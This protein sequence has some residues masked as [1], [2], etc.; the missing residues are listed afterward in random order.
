VLLAAA[1]SG[2]A[3]DAPRWKV[4]LCKPDL[5]VNWCNVDMRVT[6]IAANGKRHVDF[7]P[8]VV[9][10][11]VDCFYLYPSLPGNTT[12]LKID[13]SEKQVAIIQAA[14]FGQACRVFAPMYRQS[15]DET[16][17]ADSLAAWRD[18]LAHSNHGRG[19]VLIGHSQGAYVL[20]R[21]IQE[22]VERR[23][24]VRKLVVSAILLGGSVSVKKGSDTGGTFTRLP[25]CRR[26]RQAGCIVAYSTWGR[27]PPPDASFE[28]VGGP[29]Q[30]I[31]CVNPARPGA[32]GKVPITPVFP[33]FAPEGIVTTDVK[34]DTLY[35]AFRHKYTA[36]CV[37]KGS[38]SWLLVEDVGTPGD[39]R[40]RVQE[41][42]APTW[43]L[44]AA[45][46]N[47]AL[48]QLVALVRM[49]AAAWLANR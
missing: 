25:V 4:W 26:P 22:H 10:Q 24:A 1:T 7:G 48:E 3:A 9:R 18:Y 13:D 34:V 36:R 31:V 41:V 8:Q 45:D 29:S 43:G 19:V 30:Q 20:E 44:H 38:R 47:I 27:T 21:L 49:Q 32:T 6:E 17:Y 39:K 2:S 40:Q 42:A 35:V 33:W 12:N 28:H 15:P 23:P 14:R 16:A 11:R 5:Q 37:T 46:V